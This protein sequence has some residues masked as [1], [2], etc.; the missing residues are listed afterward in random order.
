[1]RT[2]FVGRKRE[3]QLL[4]D[5]LTSARAG[6]PRVVLCRGEPGIG[7]TRLAEEFSVVAEGYGVLAVWGAAAGSAGAPPYWPWRQM[8]RALSED[9][10]LGAVAREHRLNAA[11]A[12]LAPDVFACSEGDGDSSDCSEDRFRLF[13][14]VARLLHE[15]TRNR[16]LVIVFDD[17]HWGVVSPLLLLQ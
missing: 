8:L 1:M 12:R 11:L 15:V 17:A 14:A 16:S 2:G 9:V 10:D 4:E 3:L 5:C 13:D 6:H 7:K